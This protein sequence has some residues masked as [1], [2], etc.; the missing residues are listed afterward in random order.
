MMGKDFS[1]PKRLSGLRGASD[2]APAFL[3]LFQTFQ[4][5]NRFAE[6][7]QG[8][9]VQIV[10]T[11]ERLEP[12]RWVERLLNCAN[13]QLSLEHSNQKTYAFFT[14]QAGFNRELTFTDCG[15]EQIVGRNNYCSAPPSA[16]ICFL[17]LQPMERRPMAL[18]ARRR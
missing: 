7:E 9:R 18:P 14:Q 8:R 2:R 10:G 17:P 13:P 1:Q 16:V 4:P 11:L 5:F 6:P 12:V 15:L 3:N